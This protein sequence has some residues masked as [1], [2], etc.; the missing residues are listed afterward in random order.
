MKQ[1]NVAECREIIRKAVAETGN[2][3]VDKFWMDRD[4]TKDDDGK[5]IVACQIVDP[6]TVDVANK[7]FAKAGFSNVARC[8][9][10]AGEKD[11]ASGYS[12]AYMYIRVNSFIQR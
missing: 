7:M 6:E 3:W 9:G 1:A 12:Y 11:S 4:T 10:G 5:R 8:T 2:G